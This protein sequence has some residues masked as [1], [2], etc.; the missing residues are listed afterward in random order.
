MLLVR[1]IYHTLLASS[2]VQDQVSASSCEA[3]YFSDSSA[4][5]DLEYVGLFLSDLP[6]FPDDAKSP[7]QNRLL[8]CRPHSLVLALSLIF[9]SRLMGLVPTCVLSLV[10]LQLCPL[11]DTLRG[12]SVLTDGG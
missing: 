5:N 6:F 10:F 3:E 2:F 11:V 12:C 8:I 4:V 1:C 9:R 7:L